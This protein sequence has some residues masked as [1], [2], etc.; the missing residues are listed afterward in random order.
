MGK[1]VGI[2]RHNFIDPDFVA[3]ALTSSEKAAYPADNL[4]NFQRRT[5]IWRSNG[6][7]LIETG[8]NAIVFRETVGVDLTATVAAGDYSDIT[9]FLAA[10]KA[11]LE[12]VGAATYTCT[13]LS[14]GKIQIVSNLGGGATV[15]QLRM[16]AAASADM[17]EILGFDLVAYTG[18]A[19]YAAD[20]IRIHTDEWLEWDLGFP[21]NPGAFIMAEER[22][23]ELKISATAVV[24]LQ[25]N[26]TRN[27]G[28]PAL[29]LTIPYDKYV[30]AKWDLEDGLAGAGSSGYR[31][32]RAQI[33]DAENP[34]QY[35]ELGLVYLGEAYVTTRG[36]AVFPLTY[37]LADGSYTTYAEAGQSFS[38]E[39]PTT[40]TINLQW[41]ALTKD[42]EKELREFTEMV[43]KTRAFF[44]ILD[45]GVQADGTG[46]FSVNQLNWVKLVKQVVDARFSIAAPNYWQGQ[47]QI[48][49]EL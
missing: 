1:C 8:S 22:N 23:A 38:Q 19:T 44:V 49:E 34:R 32:W 12:L 25:A 42:E 9:T 35:V 7:F 33:I 2:C 26:W 43:K 37:E 5:Q 14:S 28:S 6:H 41:D 48:R 3:N 40:S 4:Y 27:W 17:A 16:E 11:A 13:V 36:C 20:V 18:S 39:L 10:V 29:E 30:L 21:A 24:R 45:A 47:W 15:F 31:Y 46:A